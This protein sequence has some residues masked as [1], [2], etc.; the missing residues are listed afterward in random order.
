MIVCLDCKRRKIERERDEL[1]KA[2][3]LA[4]AAMLDLARRIDLD[5]ASGADLSALD[6]AEAADFAITAAMEAKRG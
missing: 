5:N 6:G 1:R 4:K 3:E 2:C